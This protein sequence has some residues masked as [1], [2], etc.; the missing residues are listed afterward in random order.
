ML[1]FKKSKSFDLIHSR[2]SHKPVKKKGKYT[3]L[4]RQSVTEAKLRF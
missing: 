1:D 2:Q 3:P 4:H